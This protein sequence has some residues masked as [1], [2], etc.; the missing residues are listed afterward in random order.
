[1]LL[2]E[3]ANDPASLMAGE[4]PIGVVLMLVDPL[5]NDDIGVRRLGNEVQVPKSMSA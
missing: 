5:A 3:T 4:R 2:G 1:V